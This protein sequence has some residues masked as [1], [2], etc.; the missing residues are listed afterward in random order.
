MHCKE[1]W[2]DFLPSG[3]KLPQLV[4]NPK[5]QPYGQVNIV[6]EMPNDVAGSN[7]VDRMKVS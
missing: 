5:L 2:D 3:V 6:L 1:P 4:Q 7:I